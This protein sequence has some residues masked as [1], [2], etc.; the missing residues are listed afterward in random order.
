MLLIAGPVD[1]AA[2]S[3]AHDTLTGRTGVHRLPDSEEAPA[4]RCRCGY[5][6]EGEGYHD[7]IRQDPRRGP[8]G[9]PSRGET[10]QWLAARIVIQYWKDEARHKRAVSSW[11]GRNAT[12]KNKGRLQCAL[13]DRR[14]TAADASGMRLAV[15][16]VT[17]VA[18]T[19]GIWMMMAAQSSGS[20]AVAAPSCQL[21]SPSPSY[22]SLSPSPSY[23][24][25]SPS[26]SYPSLSPSPSYP[27][28]SPS[29]SAGTYTA[30]FSGDATGG[31][32][33]TAELRAFLES[34]DGQ[35]VALAPDG[36]YRV[37]SLTITAHGLTVDFRGARLVGARPGAPGILRLVDATDI[38]L[39]DAY[40]VGTG[41]KWEATA[42]KPAD[43]QDALQGEAGIH[44]SGGS[45]IILNRPKTRDTRG[46]G[47]YVGYQPGNNEPAT[48]VVIVD[49]NIRRASRNGI[50][51]VAGQVTVI[52]GHIARTGLFGIDF[53]PNDDVGARSIDGLVDGVDIRRVTDLPA[54]ASHA[55]GPYAVAAGGYSG[56]T[57]ARIEVRNLT[58]DRLRMTIR[59]TT[60]VLVCGNISRKRTTVDIT[61]GTDVAFFGNVRMTRE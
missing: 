4:G 23:P 43:N 36:I 39:N 13:D 33:V 3:P 1:G 16:I 53:E 12:P 8:S 49:P 57:K 17:S 46:D 35:H 6:V 40:V 61:G 38:V 50:A 31:T 27:S 20:G 24:S 9:V 28:L 56:A 30:I 25:L 55:S 59:D 18:V 41:Y 42:G 32:R 2:P 7:W 26:P 11:Q 51:P 5:V 34:H 10:S 14:L 22:P 29:P 58:G 54:T 52:G 37:S 21:P 15:A 47:I 19:L 44:V 48:G 45:N 60:K